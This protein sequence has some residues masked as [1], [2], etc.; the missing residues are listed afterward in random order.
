MGAVD[1]MLLHVSILAAGNITPSQPSP[2]KGGGL[3]S[4]FGPQPKTFLPKNIIPVTKLPSKHYIYT[5]I[6]I[7]NGCGIVVV[8]VG[9]A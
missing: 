3:L 2:I 8:G 9:D 5:G 1:G 6:D 7:L 4:G